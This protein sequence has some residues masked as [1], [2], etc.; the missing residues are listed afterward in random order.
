MG[1]DHAEKTKNG[2]NVLTKKQ[3]RV[4]SKECEAPCAV[5]ETAE[6]EKTEKKRTVDSI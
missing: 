3:N 6:R 1:L 5:H 2:S 4:Y